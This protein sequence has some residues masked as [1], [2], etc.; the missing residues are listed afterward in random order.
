[1]PNHIKILAEK[2]TK[3]QRSRP[4]EGKGRKGEGNRNSEK[5]RGTERKKIERMGMK[6]KEFLE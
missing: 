1:M 6:G 2:I 4:G 5:P 3:K